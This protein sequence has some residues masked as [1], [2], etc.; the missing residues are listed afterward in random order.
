MWLV[1]LIDFDGGMRGQTWAMHLFTTREKAQACADNMM[2]RKGWPDQ[3]WR[4]Y[5]DWIDER[6]RPD[7]AWDRW[8]N[9]RNR[10]VILI[11]P[12]EA[13][14]YQPVEYDDDGIPLSHRRKRK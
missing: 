11:Q 1:Q 3:V 5:A 14:V 9:N 4:P 10:M 7:P 12:I 8:S 6:C 13:D 2:K